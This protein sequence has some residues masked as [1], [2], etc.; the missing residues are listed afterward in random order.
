MAIWQ[1]DFH[2]IPN[3]FLDSATES[4]DE[5]LWDNKKISKSSIIFPE[6]LKIIKS[7]DDEIQCGDYDKTCIN[8]L[9]E[10]NYLFE[11]FCRIDLREFNID[12]LKEIVLYFQ[13]MDGSILYNNRVY[14]LSEDIL[15]RLI[16]SSDT[17]RFCTAPSDFLNDLK[18]NKINL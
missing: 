1:F 9:F 5:Y 6:F 12:L 16:L 11:M 8:Y 4:S 18:N 3:E 15:K 14:M 13:Q 17:Y 10:N 7:S 2:V